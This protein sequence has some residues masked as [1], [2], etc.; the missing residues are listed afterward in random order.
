VGGRERNEIRLRQR[1]G[2]LLITLVA[3]F[4]AQGV[5]G[6]GPVQ[7]LIVTGLAVLTLVLALRVGEVDDRLVVATGVVGA[8]VLAVIAVLALTGNAYSEAARTADALFVL[9]TPPAVMVGIR[10]TL[11]ARRRVT[12]QAVLGVV[13]LY[14]LLGMLAAAVYGAIDRIGG[15][16]FAGDVSAT[17]SNCLYFSFTT[18]TTVGYGDVTAGTRLG[19][20]LAVAEALLGQLYLVTVVALLV[21]NLRPRGG[22]TEVGGRRS[23]PDDSA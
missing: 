12:V 2:L 19:H 14:L 1:F 9:L 7:E 6:P 17:M 23:P 4:M 21:A 18:L 15:P 16:F 13:C 3:S 10:R 11:R 5:A 8:V 22:S 20:T